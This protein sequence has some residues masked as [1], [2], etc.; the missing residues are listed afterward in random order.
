MNYLILAS[1]S[2]EAKLVDMDFSR[3]LEHGGGSFI[4][5]DPEAVYRETG[6]RGLEDQVERLVRERD[7]QIVVY[8]LGCEFDFRPAFFAEQLKG[9]FRALMVGDDEHYFDVAHRYYAQCF[10]LILTT[11]A[12]LDRYALY[13][14]EAEFIP[15]MYDGQ[16]F[17]SAP[18]TP[19]SLDISFVGAMQNKIGREE[20]ARA[21]RD[22]GLEFQAY[23]LGTISGFVTRNEAIQIY[24]RSRINLNFTGGSVVT[25]F[26]YH[27]GINRR[28]RGVKGRCQM[29]ALCGSFVLS[30]YAPGIERLFDVGKEI[31][32]FHDKGELVDKVRYYLA[33]EAEREDMASKAH[34]R[35]RAQYEEREFG[36]RLVRSLE[37]RAQKKRPRQAL[38]IY[39]D[40]IFWRGFAAWRFKYLVIFLLSLRPDLFVREMALL[41]NAGTWSWRA[42]C[43]CIGL[44]LHVQARTSRLAAALAG[45][46]RGLRRM[47]RAARS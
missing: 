45:M 2:P 28:I 38:P 29:I 8:P 12:L 41:I 3:C 37:S 20:Y 34:T 7:I 18:G 24:R 47:L 22:A 33:H 6:L 42:A 11:N 40:R 32:V 14:I 9:T 46:G 5:L 15:G 19:K 35:A 25:P 21:L 43:W 44:G 13:G 31:D 17:T 36:R 4:R 10:D 39:V 30:E 1:D 27:L 16:V 23:G 26:D